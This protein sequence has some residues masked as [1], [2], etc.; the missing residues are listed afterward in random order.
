MNRRF[1][2]SL[3]AAAVAAFAVASSLPWLGCDTASDDRG[4]ADAST[5]NPS[6]V[7][8]GTAAGD[9]E[10]AGVRSLP[11]DAGIPDA[12]RPPPEPIA[13]H[14][15]LLADPLVD[16]RLA[17]GV[18]LQGEWHLSELAAPLEVRQLDPKGVANALAATA[19]TMRFD[20]GA[21]GRLRVHFDSPALPWAQGS[22]LR[23]RVERYGSLVVWPEASSYRVLPAGALRA[24]LDE[25]RADVTPLAP[26]TLASRGHGEILGYATRRVAL[27]SELGTVELEIGA[28]AEVGE[29]GQ[30]LCRMLVELVGVDPASHACAAGEVPLRAS[31]S[32]ADGGSLGLEIQSLERRDDLDPRGF[33]MPP[34]GAIRARGGLPENETFSAAGIDLRLLRHGPAIDGEPDGT[35]TAV[36]RGNDGSYL[37]LDGVPAGVVPAW[38]ERQLGP[39]RAGRYRVQWRSFLGRRI[40]AAEEIE[41]PARVVRVGEGGT[42]EE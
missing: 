42:P 38:T 27:S 34:L 12:S 7:Q 14:G 23:M 21:S 32:W 19:H 24:A 8:V 40:E 11:T 18:I 30:L 36:N 16:D 4:L 29:G 15:E 39:V 22:E 6:P 10:D 37:L 41:L 2:P 17:S 5:P 13:P 20:L 25:L 1:H 33:A 35:F 31:F 3:T 9:G 28:M 26:E